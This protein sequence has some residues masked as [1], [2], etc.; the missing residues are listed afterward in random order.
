[1][2]C[3]KIAASGKPED[4]AALAEWEPRAIAQVYWKGKKADDFAA[5][6]AAHDELDKRFPDSRDT[7]QIREEWGRDRMRAFALAVKKDD[8]ELAE[9]LQ[10]QI[11]DD[12]KWRDYYAVSETKQ[13]LVLKRWRRAS[14]AGDFE[15]ADAFVASLPDN[16]HKDDWNALEKELFS[17]LVERWKEAASRGDFAGAD[18]LFDRAVDVQRSR[19]VR[20]EL[21]PFREYLEERVKR[22]EAWAAEQLISTLEA[23]AATSGKEIV[24]GLAQIKGGRE[25]RAR[26]AAG[27]AAGAEKVLDE[28]ERAR[29]VDETWRCRQCTELWLSLFSKARAA[30]NKQEAA[31]RLTHVVELWGDIAPEAELRKAMLEQWTPAELVAL[32]DSY[33]KRRH[34]DIASR[35]YAAAKASGGAQA[36]GLDEKEER[37]AFVSLRALADQ[38]IRNVDFRAFERAEKDLR[39]IVAGRG[40]EEIRFEALAILL[41]VQAEY[42]RHL[43]ENDMFDRGEPMLHAAMHETAPLLLEARAK[44][45][46]A[47]PWAKVSPAVVERTKKRLDALLALA[48]SGEVVLPEAEPIQERL[49]ELAL[50]LAA[51]QTAVDR[52]QMDFHRERGLDILRRL[53]R[54]QRGTDAFERIITGLK[55]GIRRMHE[56]HQDVSA[57]NDL[58]A[59]YVAEVGSPGAEDPFRK[60]L[61]EILEKTAES[62]AQSSPI[63]RVFLLSLLADVL[64]DDPAGKTARD[65][66]M[67]KGLEIIAK[68][69]AQPLKAPSRKLPSGLSGLSVLCVENRTQYHLLVFLDGPERLYVR[70]NPFRRGTIVVKDGKYV[71]AVV[72]TKESIVPYK[73]ELKLA[74][75]ALCSGYSI[76][77]VGKDGEP[78]GT[79]PDEISMDHVTGEWSLLRTPPDVE[80][81]VVDPAS[82][83]VRKKR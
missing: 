13:A 30:G 31:N 12:P 36:S 5:A 69:K 28:L 67:A 52:Q 25:W 29:R 58:L 56:R 65:E 2:A 22:L 37:A 63:T 62:F 61:K 35:F 44:R 48:R 83:L 40:K 64:P 20:L 38:A 46:G 51:P 26:F 34:G 41:V 23:S 43:L 49:I 71:N 7:K 14:A 11:D 24:Q 66:A 54:R 80:G 39:S 1:A 15:A 57:L 55:D 17:Q 32:G 68:T 19:N 81:L 59:F 3:K 79:P 27:D 60:E 72:V 45:P 70:M 76:V 9:R 75:E 47:D 77:R 33:T 16:P 50:E 10:R 18:S 53:L 42:G 82:G 74:S 6:E 4:R 8:L 21:P 73:G 78:M